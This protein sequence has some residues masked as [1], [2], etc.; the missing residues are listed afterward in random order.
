MTPAIAQADDVTRRLLTC[1]RMMVLSAGQQDQRHKGE[2]DAE[3]EH[4]LTEHEGVGR[5]HG[6]GQQYQGRLSW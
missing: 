5:V 3:G 6:Q 1:S 4:D 2:G